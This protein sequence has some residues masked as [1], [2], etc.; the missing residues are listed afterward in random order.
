MNNGL[1][2][3]ENKMNSAKNG[4]ADLKPLWKRQIPGRNDEKYGEHFAFPF[5][6]I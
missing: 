5:F 3:A 2:T 4:K 6:L 1:G